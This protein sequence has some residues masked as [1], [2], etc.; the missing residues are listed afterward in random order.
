MKAAAVFICLLF[1]RVLCAQTSTEA[2]EPDRP[3]VTNGAHL[4]APGALQV[5]AGGIYTHAAPGARAF[6]SPFTVRLGVTKWIEARVGADGL[7][8]QSDGGTRQTGFGNVQLAAKVRI[9][10]DRDGAALLSLLPTVNIPTASSDK[11]LGSGAADYTV[12]VLTGADVGS[13]AHVDVNYGIGAIG[14]GGGA[15]RFAQHAASMS[16]S[17]SA[18]RWSPYGE[19]FWYSRQE[20]NGD[21]ITA[22]DA[23]AIYGVSPR[24]AIDGGALFGVSRGA[25][26]AALF[27]GVSLVVGHINLIAPRSRF[28]S[29]GVRPNRLPMSRTVSSSRMSATPTASIS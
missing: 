16:A 7:L 17:V 26:D 24:V 14:S 28:R 22:I 21:A 19:L 29:S 18:G 13:R 27:A 11:G 2:I 3:D 15:P 5:E 4:V 12:A 9:L 23:G 20:R 25:P 10:S 1:A 6:G 8:V